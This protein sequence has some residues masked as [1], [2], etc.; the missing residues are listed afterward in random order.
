MSF[1]RGYEPDIKNGCVGLSA[2]D[3]GVLEKTGDPG[4]GYC[5]IISWPWIR[6]FTCML[7]RSRICSLDVA[8]KL[9]GWSFLEFVG[10][11][12]VAD[13]PDDVKNICGI[14]IKSSL[15]FFLTIW[16]ITIA[17]CWIVN[18][19]MCLFASMF[20]V[21]AIRIRCVLYMLW[22]SLLVLYQSRGMSP[23]FTL[24]SSN[25]CLFCTIDYKIHKIKYWNVLPVFKIEMRSF[26][27]QFISNG[28]HFIERNETNSLRNWHNVMWLTF[29]L[30]WFQRFQC[31]VP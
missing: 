19:F 27:R 31:K 8:H 20:Y 29:G 24:T 16:P 26:L 10:T 25:I 11:V 23:S 7:R 17:F 22:R 21:H 5:E 30:F 4:P 18:L 3:R 15:I 1:P 12:D 13:A 9:D 28:T 14:D 2:E 6:F